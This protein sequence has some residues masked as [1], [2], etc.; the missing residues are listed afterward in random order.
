[1]ICSFAGHPRCDVVLLLGGYTQVHV[2]YR[3]VRPV[4]VVYARATG[5]YVSA[6]VAAWERLNRWVDERKVRRQVTRGFG[7]FH[8]NPQLTATELL[9]YDACMQLTTALEAEPAAGIGR[10][11]LSG[12]TYAV[13][14]HIG[15]YGPIG[16][17]FSHLHREWIPKQG[18]SVDYDRPFMAIHL[19]D[20]YIT[21][22][23]HRRTELCV[24]VVP[25][26]EYAPLDAHGED[27]GARPPLLGLA[28]GFK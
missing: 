16:G 2:A 24:P 5:D 11:T 20:P 8:D 9:R 10:Q 25:L 15:A 28:V 19:N 4:S 6:A 12:G 13:H 26:R 17:L 18:L 22:E 21:R 23:M 7:L 27:E 14:T 3:Q 1:M